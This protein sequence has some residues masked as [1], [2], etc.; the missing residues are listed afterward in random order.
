MEEE[1]SELAKAAIFEIIENQMKDNTPPITKITYDR[2][3]SEGFTHEE[4]MKLIGC[5]VS[6]E[7]F[8]IMKNENVFNEERYTDNL[9]LLPELPWED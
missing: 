4:T 1:G 9:K 2:L 8:E 6:V 3:V 5:A 7:L